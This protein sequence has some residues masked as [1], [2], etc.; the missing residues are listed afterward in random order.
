MSEKSKTMRNPFPADPNNPMKHV[1][2]N[3]GYN[4]ALDD[5]EELL[6]KESKTISNCECHKE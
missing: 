2:Q 1:Y 6:E 5:I 3:Q 4:K